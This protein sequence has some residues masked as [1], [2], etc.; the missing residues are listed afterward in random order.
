[1]IRVLRLERGFEGEL[2]VQKWPISGF[3]TF[4]VN[5]RACEG[6]RAECTGF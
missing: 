1:M 5:K 4:K 3:V 2:L 6:Q